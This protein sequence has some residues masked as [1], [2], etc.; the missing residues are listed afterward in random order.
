MNGAERGVWVWEGWGRNALLNDTEES[1]NQTW[2]PTQSV[3]HTSVPPIWSPT[4]WVSIYIYTSP[5]L[6]GHP[7]D[8]DAALGP[9]RPGFRTLRGEHRLN[10][11][12]ARRRF[13]RFMVF[14]FFAYFS[15][16][17]MGCIFG[18]T[19]FVL[20]S[21]GCVDSGRW[22]FQGVVSPRLR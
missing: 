6:R 12:S 14:L 1:H 17:Q 7:N 3:H 19:I 20:S 5:K 2:L 21:I 15:M 13:V 4:S 11:A 16:L 22:F 9:C 18:L 8:N 10:L